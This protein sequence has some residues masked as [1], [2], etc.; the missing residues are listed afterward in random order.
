MMH[1]H[2]HRGARFKGAGAA[3]C[4]CL[5][6]DKEVRGGAEQTQRGCEPDARQPDGGVH[7]IACAACMPWSLGALPA[8]T[9]HL[10]S[11]VNTTPGA[12][13]HKLQELESLAGQVV[14]FMLF[15]HQDKPGQPVARNKINEVITAEFKDHA[16]SRKLP[17]VSVGPSC[18]TMYGGEG[19]QG[20]SA[21]IP[22]WGGIMSTLMLSCCMYA[23]SSGRCTRSSLGLTLRAPWAPSPSHAGGGGPCAVPD[24]LSVWAGDAGGGAQ[25]R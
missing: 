5:S 23:C 9:S 12:F 11:A 18:K 14:R 4:A 7:A 8:L 22:G 2:L 1:L 17:Q 20:T 10:F 13:A 25:E 19:G 24:D 3:L 21:C 16:Q 15:S 6:A